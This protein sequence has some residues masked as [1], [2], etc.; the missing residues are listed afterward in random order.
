MD[1]TSN[2]YYQ[3][4]GKPHFKQVVLKVVPNSS[5]RALLLKTGSVDIADGLTLDEVNAL[6]GAAG[7]KVLDIPSR[8]QYEV[9]LNNSIPPFTNRLVRQALSYAVPYQSIIQSVFSGHALLPMGAVP[10][11]GQMFDPSTWPYRYDLAKAKSLLAKAGYPHGLKFTLDITA[12]DAISQDLAVV[13]QSALSKI[14]VQMTINSQ[15]AAIFAEQLDTKKHQAWLEDVLWYVND[16]AYV[17]NSFYRCSALLNWT[18]HC[19]KAVDNT[20]ATM[21][22]QWRPAQRTAKRAEAST[23]Q[24]LINADAPTLILAEPDLQVAM[25]STINGF[26]AAPDEETLY[27]YLGGSG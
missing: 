6:R 18:N 15:T 9:G 13:L 24:R 1:L 22:N 20:I 3:G 10:D 17:G 7:V 23:M 25:R 8:D 12:G 21:L 19:N 27:N 14:G 16:P 5:E 4:P 11:R 2:P 26:V